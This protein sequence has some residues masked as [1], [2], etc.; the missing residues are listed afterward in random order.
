MNALKKPAPDNTSSN[1]SRLIFTALVAAIL[2][3]V[4]GCIP[5]LNPLFTE[6]DLEFDPALLGTWAEK[7]DSEQWTFE[8]SS[9]EKDAKGY[10]LH[11]VDDKHHKADF[12]A[13]LCK[14]KDARYLDIEL[15]KLHED[16]NVN[17]LGLVSLIPGHLFFRVAQVEPELK[18]IFPDG[19]RLKELVTSSP[20][21]LSYRSNNNSFYLT[22]ST[23]DLQAFFIKHADDK[24]LFKTENDDGMKRVK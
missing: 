15:S 1:D 2:L 4:A 19:D 7:P 12:N 10:L 20:K 23:K 18:L 5:S 21:S 8:R 16:D 9:N 3:L 17:E 11:H 13:H 6:K 14:L 24:K 22:A